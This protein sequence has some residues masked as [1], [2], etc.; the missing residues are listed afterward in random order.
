MKGPF[1]GWASAAAFA[2]VGTLTRRAATRDREWL[3]ALGAELEEVDGGWSRLSWAL[4]AVR[5]HWASRHRIAGLQHVS[6]GEKQMT[7]AIVDRFQNPVSIFAYSAAGFLVWWLALGGAMRLTNAGSTSWA[8]SEIVIGLACLIG[9]AIGV[10]LRMSLLAWFLVAFVGVFVSE[11][12]MHSL[13]GIKSVQGG[14][15]HWT[16]LGAALLAVVGFVRFERRFFPAAA[17][18]F[19]CIFA[20]SAAEALS[21]LI[22]G[23]QPFRDRV[24]HLA[25]FASA[26]VAAALAATLVSDRSTA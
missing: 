19:A 20:F 25:I 23:L 24:T 12:T 8:R 6:T 21:H 16:V 11:F 9:V 17:A 4:G 7:H 1:D 5:V 2:I 3:D 15:A 26:A 22:W 13:F 10:T 18:A 14:P